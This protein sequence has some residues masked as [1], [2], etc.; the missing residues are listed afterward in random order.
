MAITERD[1][2]MKVK[3]VGN[4]FCAGEKAGPFIG[5]TEAI[6]TGSLAGLR[7]RLRHRP[8]LTAK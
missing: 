1:E 3:G 5:H 4:L 6:V 7:L 2:Y 8:M